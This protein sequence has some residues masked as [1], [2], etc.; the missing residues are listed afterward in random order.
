MSPRAGQIMPSPT[1]SLLSTSPPTPYQL[2]CTGWCHSPPHPDPWPGELSLVFLEALDPVPV[3]THSSPTAASFLM[4]LRHLRAKFPSSE[5]RQSPFF[6]LTPVPRV[7]LSDLHLQ[8]CGETPHC[9]SHFF[10][11]G[12]CRFTYLYR[13]APSS[14]P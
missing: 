7:S 5:R 10:R 14:S 11:V 6:A 1:N 2:V 3:G 4:F 12:S 9:L 13:E 8:L